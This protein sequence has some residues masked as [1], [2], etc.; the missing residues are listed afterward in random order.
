MLIVFISK[1][2]LT[3]PLNNSSHKFMRFLYF[4]LSSSCQIYPLDCVPLGTVTEWLRTGRV[5][6]EEG[7][8]TVGNLCWESAAPVLT[9]TAWIWDICPMV[10]ETFSTFQNES[11]G[12][13]TLLDPSWVASLGEPRWWSLRLPTWLQPD[14]QPDL[15]PEVRR[16]HR[17]HCKE[18][19][20]LRL[21]HTPSACL[22]VTWVESC[23]AEGKV[24]KFMSY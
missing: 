22:I 14:L 20:Q 2:C 12:T 3:F 11:T 15:Q 1:S 10:W 17:S 19:S 6:M 9:P 4:V 24:R 5:F 23:D 18:G 8:R 13:V 7:S 21:W 16:P